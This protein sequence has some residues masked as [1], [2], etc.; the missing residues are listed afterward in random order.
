MPWRSKAQG[1]MQASPIPTLLPSNRHVFAK[2]SGSPHQGSCRCIVQ[3]RPRDSQRHPVEPC[4]ERLLDAKHHLF[5]TGTRVDCHGLTVSASA[6]PL[7]LTVSATVSVAMVQGGR[8]LPGTAIPR[9]AKPASRTCALP[10]SLH[11][12]DA[13]RYGPLR[14]THRVL[15]HLVAVLVNRLEPGFRRYFLNAHG[16]RGRAAQVARE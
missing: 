14:K 16:R 6:L 2:A 7:N 15:L 5:P 10:A 3:G 1:P 13:E 12:Q 8:S 9:C 11:Q 4:W